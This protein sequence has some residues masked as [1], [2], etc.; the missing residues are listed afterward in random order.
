MAAP[1]KKGLD[2]G[3]IFG[4]PGKHKPGALDDEADHDEARDM[5]ISAF[6]DT[7][8]KNEE[9]SNLVDA[10]KEYI[11]SC[12]RQLEAEPH[13]EGEHEDENEE[14]EDEDEGY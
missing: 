5:L 8:I 14:P 9:A 7:G 2:V 11:H 13:E 3:I 4:A 6:H 12:F 10:L 1:A